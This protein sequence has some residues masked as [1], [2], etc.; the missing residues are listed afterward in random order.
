MGFRKVTRREF[1]S[2][3]TAAAGL[4]ILPGTAWSAFDAPFD[5][6]LLSSAHNKAVQPFTLNQVSLLDGPFK[7]A[8]ET[9][10]KYLHLLPSDR[11]LHM[12]R[13][14]AGFSS[15]AEP[16]G[17]WEDP[18]CELRG[19]FTG[20]H[21]LSASAQ[22]CAATGDDELK[23][24]ANAMV[25]ELSRCQKANGGGYL[26]AYPTELFKRLRNR[27]NV[28]APFYTYHKIMAGHFDMYR[29]L[30]N[31]Q[32]LETA[33]KMAHWA[34]AWA[35]DIPDVQMQ[36]ILYVEYGGMQEVLAN[37]YGATGKE[38]YLALSHRFDHHSF[39]DP[40]ADH[41]DRLQG[42]HANTHVPQVIGAARRYEL[43]HD[44]RDREISDF[45]WHDVTSRRC[46]CTG[47]T[48]NYEH[49][50]T[51]P[52][53]LASQ[54]SNQTQ[55]CCVEYNTL[56]LTRHVY[57]WTGDPAM[58][59]YYERTLFNSR[60]GTQHPTNGM[61]MYFMPMAAGWWKF[62]S[63]PY[64]S[65]WCCVGTGVEEFSKFANSIFWHD[66]NEIYVNLF[67]PSELDWKEKG[68]RL[69]QETQFPEEESTALTFRSARPVRMALNI[70]VPWW[71]GKDVT[72][73][74]NG[75]SHEVKAVPS[76]YVRLH[77]KWKDGDKVEISLPMNLHADA[78]P[79][80]GT[81]QAAMYGPLVLAGR[82]GKGD[83]TSDKMY[84]G[85]NH[86]PKGKPASAP[87]IQA[88][89]SGVTSWVEKVDG[90][91][92]TFQTVGQKQALSLIPLNRLFGE[93]YAVYW[94]MQ[95]QT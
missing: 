64:D 32:A 38:E 1:I 55:E 65:F 33:E 16:L 12:F 83:L 57:S 88:A 62:F 54:L 92:L 69:R 7:D 46:Y 28:W 74:I 80:D 78:M 3:G 73:K 89:K 82:L 42:L 35:K 90:E 29:H 94:H 77:R 85:N 34:G 21:Y 11:L 58:M 68:I 4:A 86:I 66:G 22:M 10:R 63:Q 45:F 8:M 79:D 81:I 91:P 47:G 36:R 70:R 43:E 9:N 27:Q 75:K 56:K 13:L 93:H 76:S 31:E 39:F 5:A 84:G 61:K 24:K 20:G 26:S 59:D 49:W 15:S 25:E 48:S 71:V 23:S 44:R 6:P 37:L 2:R 14:T 40:L 67:I 19:H 60:L 51:P 18:H 95:S 17:G 41:Q 52:G 72:V 50:R 53:I 30:G 87:E